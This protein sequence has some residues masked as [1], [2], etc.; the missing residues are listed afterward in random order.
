M[1]LKLSR[2]EWKRLC[3]S[4]IEIEA[5]AHEL[6]GT[7]KHHGWFRNLNQSRYDELDLIGKEEFEDIVAI[8]LVAAAHARSTTSGS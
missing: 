2:E 4:E 3:P 6:F 5:A 7:G 1:H 8:I